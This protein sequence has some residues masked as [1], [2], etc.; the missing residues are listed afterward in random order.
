MFTPLDAATDAAPPRPRPGP[1]RVVTLGV[2]CGQIHDYSA[3]CA[4]ELSEVTVKAADPLFGEW[5]IRETHFRVLGAE[6]LPLGTSYP[7]V[8]QRL[9]L[10]AKRLHDRDSR[11][12]YHALV[13]ATGVGRPVVD[14]IR[15]S[16]IPQC[17]VTA[18]TLTGGERG[19]PDVLWK[20]EASIGKA[21]MVSRLQAL[22]Q[23]QRLVAPVDP[24]MAA[25]ADE[26]KVY[27]IKAKPD[28][29]HLQTGAF[30]VGTHDDLVTALGLA[31]LVDLQEVRYGVAF[32][33]LPSAAL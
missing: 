21:Y 22:L 25:M 17:H 4:V 10:L 13:D 32:G 23:S 30:Q 18:V 12:D 6:R 7:A 27:E 26:L 28:T 11:G 31:C 2:D 9:C 19:A 8:A 14:L 24:D 16:I 29:G 20:L 1:Y 3:I 5:P 33:E 15:G